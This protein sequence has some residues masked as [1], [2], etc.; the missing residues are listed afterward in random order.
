MPLLRVR[1]EAKQGAEAYHHGLPHLCAKDMSASFAS[2]QLY[3]EV[4]APN[5]QK[6][7]FLK[8]TTVQNVHLA[9]CCYVV[10]CV[11]GVDVL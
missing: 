3:R 9:S 1:E 11:Y 2:P 8:A 4:A 7:A 5:S 10:L 6:P